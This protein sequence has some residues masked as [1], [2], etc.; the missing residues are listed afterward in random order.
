[1]SVTELLEQ[2]A[3]LFA[4]AQTIIETPASGDDLTK[5]EERKVDEMFA[6]A[7]KLTAKINVE[8]RN[9][10][11][12][13]L[14]S[15]VNRPAQNLG[16]V[17]EGGSRSAENDKSESRAFDNWMRQEAGPEFRASM[18]STTNSAAIP[19]EWTNYIVEKLYQENVMRRLCPIKTSAADTKIVIEGGAVTEAGCVAEGVEIGESDTTS[20]ATSSVTVDAFMRRPEVWATIEL[21][22]DS[23]FNL[24]AYI[25]NKIGV[26]VGRGEEKDFIQGAGST[27]P[28]GLATQVTTTSTRTADT[29]T[30]LDNFDTDDLWD[31]VFKLPPA[32]RSRPST[33]ILC[34]DAFVKALRKLT[35]DAGRSLW[36]PSDRYSDLRDGM[37]GTIAGIPYYTSPYM[38]ETDGTMDA[39]IGDFN[40]AEVWQ[41]AGMT[42]FQDPFSLSSS[43][44]VKFIARMRSDFKVTQVEAFV[45]M[46]SL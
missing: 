9:S 32:Y 5:E 20:L 19:T 28:T 31:F 24:D 4:N 27:E 39:F 33:A 16:P 14:E 17:S 35:D 12:R 3:K 36:Q 11:L 18:T 2:R 38:D 45:E 30:Y 1:M 22:A 13:T 42:M 23:S 15:E 21:L 6:D 25:G 7:D 26:K 29:S 37:P 41:R 34:S 46:V 44:K 43:G 8:E 40:Y 10:R